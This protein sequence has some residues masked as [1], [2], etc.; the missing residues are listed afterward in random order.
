MTQLQ[1]T[2][3]IIEKLT[4]KKITVDVEFL[5]GVER[6]RTFDE[7]LSKNTD[8]NKIMKPNVS[9]ANNSLCG[10]SKIGDGENIH[11]AI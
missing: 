7:V 2:S 4:Q 6:R 5:E 10:N 9:K 3:V 11:L 8:N 1:K